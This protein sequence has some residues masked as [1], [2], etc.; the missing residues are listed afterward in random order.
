[1]QFRLIESGLKMISTNSTGLLLSFGCMNQ[2]RLTLFSSQIGFVF[3]ERI[4]FCISSGL[5]PIEVEESWTGMI[6]PIKR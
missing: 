5:H 1:M 2:P 6:K 3:F 4:G